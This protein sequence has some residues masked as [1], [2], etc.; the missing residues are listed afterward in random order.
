MSERGEES[1]YDLINDDEN[2]VDMMSQLACVV[3]G[4]LLTI[5]VVC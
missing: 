2:V 1:F 4:N 3:Q 5:S